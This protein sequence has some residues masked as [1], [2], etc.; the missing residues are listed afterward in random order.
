MTQKIYISAVNLVKSGTTNGKNW[1]IF[2][3]VDPQGKKYGTFESKYQGM[4]GQEIDAEVEEKTVEKNG[5]TYKNLNIVEP[6]KPVLNEQMWARLIALEKRMGEVEA[7][8]AG[9][10]VSGDDK[11]VNIPEDD[12][13]EKINSELAG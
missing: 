4:V 10:E 13:I 7:W 9:V 3:V 1:Q 6:K 11:V 12:D 5:K 2:N 8:Q